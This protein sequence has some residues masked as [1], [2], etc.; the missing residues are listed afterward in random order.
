MDKELSEAIEA[1]VDK[2]LKKVTADLD[3]RTD[4]KLVAL[5]KALGEELPKLLLRRDV[6]KAIV[7]KGSGAAI[8][9]GVL[10]FP[11]AVGSLFRPRRAP[12]KASRKAPAAAVPVPA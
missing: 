1:A 2:K 3:A 5:E 9:D 6:A 4:R 8:V 11:R 10:F 7:M 12:E